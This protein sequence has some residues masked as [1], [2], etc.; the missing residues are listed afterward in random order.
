MTV[1]MMGST[2]DEKTISVQKEG[3]RDVG[4]VLHENSKIDEGME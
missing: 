1:V 4:R 2:F 3:R